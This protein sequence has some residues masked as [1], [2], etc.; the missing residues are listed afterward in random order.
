MFEHAVQQVH[1]AVV[2]NGYDRR[3]V[4]ADVA[5]YER[6]ASE[7]RTRLEEAER[8]L[9]EATRR[10]RALEAKLA[11]IEDRS[12]GSGP[13][14]AAP[15]AELAER[16][17][18]TVTAAG[19]ELP[20]QILSEAE[21][22]RAR[23]ERLA[24]DVREVARFRAARIVGSARRDRRQA[25]ELVAEARRQVDQYIDEGRSIAE[26]REQAVWDRAHAQLR[27]PMLEVDEARRHGRA[28]RRELRRLQDLRDEY[29]Q[30]VV[31]RPDRVPR[32]L[33]E[34]VG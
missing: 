15:V 12:P 34:D 30:R 1:F 11:A 24:S 20:S 9:A 28:M 14:G 17:L 25:D 33:V 32:E 2:R 6:R 8:S 5:E 29:W 4:D 31:S 13:P 16:L 23:I 19:Q 3:Q 21:R 27:Q 10:A 7:A 26:E 18:E 22:D